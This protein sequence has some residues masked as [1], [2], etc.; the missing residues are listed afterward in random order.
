MRLRSF[1]FLIPLAAAPAFAATVHLKVQ[2]DNP[3]AGQPVKLTVKAL[4][5]VPVDLPAEPVIYVDEGQGFKVRPDLRCS[6]GSG[7]AAVRL[8]ADREMTASCEL[9][10][11][12]GSGRQ[13][14]RLGYKL[15]ETVSTSN[16]VTLEVKAPAEARATK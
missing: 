8:Q 6:L 1:V 15:G 12:S 2:A 5:R 14:V 4:S 16:A 9:P 10:P 13:R 7:A 11:L 3:Q